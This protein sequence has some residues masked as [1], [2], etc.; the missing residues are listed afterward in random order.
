MPIPITTTPSPAPPA[1]VPT[2]EPPACPDMGGTTASPVHLL[3]VPGVELQNTVAP[4]SPGAGYAA[5]MPADTPPL[6][7]LRGVVA[8][9]TPEYRDDVN[10]GLG[11]ATLNFTDGVSSSDFGYLFPDELVGTLYRTTINGMDP[12]RAWAAAMSTDALSP[13]A[14]GGGRALSIYR[15]ARVEVGSVGLNVSTERQGPDWKDPTLTDVA[16]FA[17]YTRYMAYTLQIRFDSDCKRDT[18]LYRAG[19]SGIADLL[20]SADKNGL[21]QF[22]VAANAE[23]AFGAIVLGQAAEAQAALDATKCATNALP[24][25]AALVHQFDTL[26]QS[27]GSDP[28]PTSF[29]PSPSGNLD[30]YIDRFTHQ[31]KGFLLP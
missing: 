28:L 18:F 6:Q 22:L 19:G 23:I 24:E 26:F 20:P 13:L 27:L 3:T 16:R 11:S 15:V 29:D 12:A 21:G 17:S 25:C 1:T 31:D 8:V 10:D 5:N 14:M 2:K 7:R 30:W 4:F 9:G